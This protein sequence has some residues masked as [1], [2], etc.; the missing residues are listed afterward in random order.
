MVWGKPLKKTHT[1]SGS[2][3]VRTRDLPNVKWR[4]RRLATVLDTGQRFVPVLFEV[5]SANEQKRLRLGKSELDKKTMVFF[6]TTCIQTRDSTALSRVTPA[7]KKDR[8]TSIRPRRWIRQFDRSRGLVVAIVVLFSVANQQ[9][10][11]NSLFL[12]NDR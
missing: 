11:P 2:T 7:G 9:G 3:G 8:S 1:W 5:S 12:S 6:E 4:A 10:V